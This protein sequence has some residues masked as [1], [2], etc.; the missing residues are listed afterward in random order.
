MIAEMS[1]LSPKHRQD[2]E[3]EAKK[4]RKVVEKTNAGGQLGG[5][6]FGQEPDDGMAPPKSVRASRG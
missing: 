4:I 5:T 1:V 3:A 2:A 6:F